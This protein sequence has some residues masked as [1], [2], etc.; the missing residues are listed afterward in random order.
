MISNF[1]IHRRNYG[2]WDVCDSTGRLFMVRGGPGKYLVS[3]VRKD[4]DNTWKEF[5]TL[6]ACMSYICDDLMFELIIADG[7]N[8]VVIE[9]WNV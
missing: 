6:T 9:S 3:D 4:R 2:H 5:K 1:G 8:P 7:Q